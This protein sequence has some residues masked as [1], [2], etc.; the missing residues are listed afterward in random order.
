MRWGRWVC[1]AVAGCV[2]LFAAAAAS[3]SFACSAQS[4]LSL[5]PEAATP[6]QTVAVEGSRWST[7]PTAAPIEIRLDGPDGHLLWSGQPDATGSVAASFVLPD[8]VPGD[9]VVIAYRRDAAGNAM[10]GTPAR[11][12]LAVPDANAAAPTPVAGL[13]DRQDPVPVTAAPAEPSPAPAAAPA[14][15]GTPVT[16]AAPAPLRRAAPAPAAVPVPA[17]PPAPAAVPAP[18][19]APA[20]VPR[21]APAPVQNTLSAPAPAPRAAA[22]HGDGRSRL[23]LALVACVVV[24]CAASTAVVVG[25]TR[26]RPR[27]SATPTKYGG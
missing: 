24:L 20:A 11:A 17:I 16:T 21:P 10:P 22:R 1:L 4:L 23:A 7:D 8:V 2:G 13:V 27:R 3:P 18:S 9:H 15:A 5:R 14:P 19:P 26:A 12:A 25:S 6:G